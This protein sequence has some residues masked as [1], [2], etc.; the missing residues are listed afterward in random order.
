[1]PAVGAKGTDYRYAY[2]GSIACTK[3]NNLSGDFES[4]VV[5]FTV[6]QTPTKITNNNN[7]N[8]CKKSV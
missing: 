7:N 2:T 5:A 4:Y 1:M 3:V 6:T 8:D